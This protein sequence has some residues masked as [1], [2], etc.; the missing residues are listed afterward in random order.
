MSQL[1]R[2]FVRGYDSVLEISIRHIEIKGV[3]DD[4]DPNK[5]ECTEVL[6]CS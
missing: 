1:S 2:V 6:F 3:H 4:L 5:S